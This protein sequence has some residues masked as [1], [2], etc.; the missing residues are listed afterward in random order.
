M[1]RRARVHG[2]TQ[3]GAISCARTDLVRPRGSFIGMRRSY[4]ALCVPSP[5]RCDVFLVCVRVSEEEFVTA[6]TWG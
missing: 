5:V 1:A 4:Y 2:A 3:G 6:S